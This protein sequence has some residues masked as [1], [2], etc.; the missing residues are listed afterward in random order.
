QT[1][2]GELG[3]RHGGGAAHQKTAIAEAGGAVQ[4]APVL[5]GADRALCRTESQDAVRA[6][7]VQCLNAVHDQ[8]RA[9][10]VT[11]V[12]LDPREGDVPCRLEFFAE[13]IRKTGSQ[14]DVVSAEY[15]VVD[16]A[17]IGKYRSE[18]GR[19]EAERAWIDRGRDR[20]NVLVK[21]ARA[22]V[23]ELCRRDGAVVIQSIG[24]RVA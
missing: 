6:G 13:L 2:V 9:E 7:V 20:R 16:A 21:V 17:D 18:E 22:Q 15:S 19:P 11:M 10:L 12:A 8:V 4:T 24:I 14:T 3:N 5:P 1:R 23:Q